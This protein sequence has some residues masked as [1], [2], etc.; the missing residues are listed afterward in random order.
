VHGNRSK[1]V[2]DAG[3]VGRSLPTSPGPFLFH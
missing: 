2:V 3:V 1:A